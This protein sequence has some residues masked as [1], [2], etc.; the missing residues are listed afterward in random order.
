MQ[1]TLKAIR[2]SSGYSMESV[3]EFCGIPIDVYGEIEND[4]SQVKLSLIQ[5]IATFYGVALS[6]IH[7][8]TEANCIKHNQGLTTF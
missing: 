3:A 4:P 6:L 8:G 5:K 7:S 2:I 1:F